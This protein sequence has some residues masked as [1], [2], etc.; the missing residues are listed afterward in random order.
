MDILAALT[1]GLLGS[2][3][4]I[5]MC[6]PLVLAVP[7][8]AHSKWRFIAER[9]LYNSGRAVTYGMM[10]AVLGIV[11]KNVLLSV[12]QDV[13]MV[14]GVV[15]LLTVSIP[16]GFKSRF[17][18]FSPLKKVYGFVQQYFSLMLHKR[19][20]TAL[21]ILGML[22]GLLPCGLVYT[23]LLGAIA[24]ADVWHSAL[25][26]IVFGLGTIPALVIVSLT[27]KIISVKFRSLLT[28]MI[29]VFSIALALILILRGMNLG[30]PLLSPKITHTTTQTETKT[31][32][33]CCE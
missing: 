24:V 4:C 2:I 21:F 31:D 33:D 15:I 22:N 1:L 29:P 3:H 18:K 17:E 11:G 5:G 16:F 30:I 6:G 23:A 10:G 20:Y 8:S 32:V 12:Q 25:F 9:I 13:S 28:R 19:G 26:M 14:L 27:G 7:S